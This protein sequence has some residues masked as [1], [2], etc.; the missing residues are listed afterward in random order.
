M[1]LDAQLRVVFINKIFSCEHE[2]Y[3]SISR[4]EKNEKFHV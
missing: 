1:S 4:L 3:D 2:F